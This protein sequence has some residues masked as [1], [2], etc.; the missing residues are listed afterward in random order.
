MRGRPFP[1]KTPLWFWGPP[2][3][4]ELAEEAKRLGLKRFFTERPCKY[5]HVCERIADPPHGTCL[6]CYRISQQKWEQ[7]N[8]GSRNA[9]QVDRY[10]KNP[11]IFRKRS[12]E[13]QRRIRLD[14]VRREQQRQYQNR[15]LRNWRRR[16]RDDPHY[17]AK[18]RLQKQKWK[19]RRYREDAWYRAKRAAEFSRWYVQSIAAVRFLREIGAGD[20]DKATAV[21]V[22]KKLGIKF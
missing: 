2:E 13:N 10:W 15:W 1:H 11:E 21:T 6:E 3:I 12:N 20:F 22:V 16:T 18:R 19:A 17:R 14:P 9:Y 4:K 7:Q 5:G 8:R